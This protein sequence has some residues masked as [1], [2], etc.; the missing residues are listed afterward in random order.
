MVLKDFFCFKEKRSVLGTKRETG[1]LQRERMGK[2]LATETNKLR[3]FLEKK[4][5]HVWIL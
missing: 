5:S 4:Q 2:V 1:E 3:T